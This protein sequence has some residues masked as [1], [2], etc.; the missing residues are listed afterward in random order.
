MN[1]KTC[2]QLEQEGFPQPVLQETQYW[3]EKV[4]PDD[5]IKLFIIFSNTEATC[6]LE[7]HEVWYL[8]GNEQLVYCPTELELLAQLPYVTLESGVTWNGWKISY[9]DGFSTIEI[10]VINE[11]L[12]D[13]LTNLWL[14]ETSLRK[15]QS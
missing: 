3:Y 12:W 13:T 6:V 4:G 11:E 7:N 1:F 2:V 5:G 10:N 15:G 8:N 14:N 9:D